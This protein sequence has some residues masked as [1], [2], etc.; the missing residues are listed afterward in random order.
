MGQSE[1]IRILHASSVAYH[2]CGVLILGK[3]GAGKS[4]LALKLMALG[5]DLVSDDRTVLKTE[6]SQTR[7]LA[8]ETIQG[9]IEVRGFG[10]LQGCPSVAADL[11]C[12]VDLDQQ[13]TTRLPQV[14]FW[15]GDSGARMFHN[16]AT[17]AFPYA[18]LQYLKNTCKTA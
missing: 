14:R 17:E 13:E 10:I 9:A 5:C 4:T 3:S 8:P 2:S 18:L 7:L 12:V 1:N 15:P 16:S 6:G 11:I